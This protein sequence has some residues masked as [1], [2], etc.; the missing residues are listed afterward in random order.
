LARNR[1]PS[2]RIHGNRSQAQRTQALAGFKAGKFRVLVATDIAARGIDVEE[3]SHVVNFDVPAVPGDYIHR[4]RRAARAGATGDAFTF[5]SPE[6]E[7]DLR[8]IERAIGKRLPRILVP[9]FD[10]GKAPA[11][12]FEVPLAERIAAIRARKAQERARAREKELRR[13]NSGR[14]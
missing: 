6:E 10:Y 14:A 2:E 7:A 13:R 8:A 1:V 3:L 12:R 9:G 5:V 11:E 4:I